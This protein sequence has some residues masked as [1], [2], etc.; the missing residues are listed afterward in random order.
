MTIVGLNSLNIAFLA[1][2]AYAMAYIGLTRL[3][4][5]RLR[6]RHPDVY[7]GIAIPGPFGTDEIV[8]SWNMV[9]FIIN[10]SHARLG[11]KTLSGLA[12]TALIALCV[13]PVV[14]LAGAVY[15]VAAA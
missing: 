2:L 15:A 3:V 11:D 5:R 1:V 10:R 8:K 6:L 4:R 14:V 9:N 12:D 7:R 13:S